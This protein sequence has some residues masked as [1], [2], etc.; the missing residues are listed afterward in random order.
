MEA[1]KWTSSFRTPRLQVVPNCTYHGSRCFKTSV[2]L[3]PELS[4]LLTPK[5]GHTDSTTCS[6][7]WGSRCESNPLVITITG[8]D[9]SAESGVLSNK[10]RALSNGKPSMEEVAASLDLAPFNIETVGTSILEDGTTQIT[11]RLVGV[12]R[13]VTDRIQANIEQRVSQGQNIALLDSVNTRPFDW[14][15][16]HGR[17]LPGARDFDGHRTPHHGDFDG[18]HHDHHDGDGKSGLETALMLVSSLCVF[19]VLVVVVLL[20][21]LRHN[22]VQFDNNQ[23]RLLAKNRAA[24][25]YASSGDEAAATPPSG[26]NPLSAGQ[27]NTDVTIDFFDM[28][29]R[30]S[31]SGILKPSQGFGRLEDEPEH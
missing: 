20:T 1:K 31:L 16:H 8:D 18:Y 4:L 2:Q 12:E 24:N 30:S 11:F 15:H 14:R 7:E 5:Q 17:G 19:L 26:G 10:F 6:L 25:N 13:H 29:R 22:K 23:S 27:Q 28:R 9:G 3:I 21:K